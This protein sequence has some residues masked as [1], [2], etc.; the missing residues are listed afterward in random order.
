MAR[1]FLKSVQMSDPS[2]TPKV[3]FLVMFYML[4]AW[5]SSLFGRTASIEAPPR[6][7]FLRRLASRASE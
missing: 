6:A 2:N 1:E 3:R 5:L 7:E 4:R